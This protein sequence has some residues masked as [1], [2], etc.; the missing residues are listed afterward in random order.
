MRFLKLGYDEFRSLIRIS[1]AKPF[2]SAR[3]APAHDYIALYEQFIS[4]R[5]QDEYDHIHAVRFRETA[6]VFG[7][8][9]E[10]G[11][12]I[13]E[14]GGYGRIGLFARETLGACCQAYEGEL[15]E[16]FDLADRAFD[17]VLCLEVVEHMKDR[18]SLETDQWPPDREYWN[19]SGA[20]NLL[21]ESHRILRPGGYLLLTTPN[22]TS[23]DTIAKILGGDHPFMFDR[24]CGNWRRSRSKPLPNTS[25]LLSKNSERFSHGPN[26]VKSFV[27]RFQR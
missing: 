24:M 18:P 23:L 1:R 15:R 7:T 4:G 20:L 22:A 13:V 26:A 27:R 9:L 2:P 12:R 10:G 16:P 8:Y 14:L 6:K 11:K 21:A 19:Y 5:P 17:V 3:D 25:A